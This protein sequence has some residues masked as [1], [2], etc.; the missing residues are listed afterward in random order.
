MYK[1]S[2]YIKLDE[3]V[4]KIIVD[5]LSKE[6]MLGFEDHY[7]TSYG[8]KYPLID[9]CIYDFKIFQKEAFFSKALSLW[10][11]GQEEFEEEFDN[12][13]VNLKLMD[14]KRDYKLMNRRDGIVYQNI[15]ILGSCLDVGGYQGRIREYMDKDQKYLSI[16]P[17]LRV[18]DGIEKQLNLLKHYTCLN[19]KVNFLSGYGEYLPIKSNSFDT[20]HMRSCLDHMFLPELAIL[21]AFRVLKDNGQIIIGV[22]V[23]G[24]KFGL[25]PNFIKKRIKQ[26]LAMMNIEKYIDHHMWHPTYSELCKLLEI[27]GFSIEKTHWQEGFDN[28]VCYVKALKSK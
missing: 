16:D 3:W 24:G 5:P 22:Y 2:S 11:H 28:T 12:Q 10:G 9:N 21:E 4:K 7:L 27:S 18:F 1:D 20:V 14:S 23:E 26:I 13:R 8:K 6:K 19:K 15:P 17:M 25:K